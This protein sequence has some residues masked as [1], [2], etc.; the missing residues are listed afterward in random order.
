M[1]VTQLM[2][3]EAIKESGEKGMSM[4]EIQTKFSLKARPKST[5]D[6]ILSAENSPVYREKETNTSSGRGI[7]Y[8]YYFRTPV[9]ETKPNEESKNAEGY[10]DPTAAKAIK[11]LERSNGF[12]PGGIYE[13][14]T[15]PGSFFLIIDASNSEC[16]QGYVVGKSADNETNAST[17]C[18]QAG[19]H[20]D[21]VRTNQLTYAKYGWLNRMFNRRCPFEALK[22]ILVKSP[23]R[24]SIVVKVGDDTLAKN[25][26]SILFEDSSAEDKTPEDIVKSVMSL[27]SD[28]NIFESAI[29]DMGNALGFDMTKTDLP[30]L[31]KAVV[32]LSRDCSSL[33]S[34]NSN[35]VSASSK[36]YHA[37]GQIAE[38]I[39]A[40]TGD[41]EGLVDK[42][43]DLVAEREEYHHS[44]SKDILMELRLKTKEAEIWKYAFDKVTGG[45]IS[46]NLD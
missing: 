31:V 37:L 24:N 32:K 15:R 42:V 22:E 9:I 17:V 16:A 5:L 38:A 30:D 27:L 14:R 7:Q 39:G 18:W 25:L 19:K 28:A 46:E 8:R 45:T 13:F 43:I 12:M 35:L 2:I 23:L 6:A 26:C 11:N 10:S 4:S 33:A 41:P 34:N 29:S 21:I 3:I 44:D 20:Y 40:E 36:L 1:K